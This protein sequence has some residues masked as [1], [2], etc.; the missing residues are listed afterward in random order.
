[1]PA[2]ATPLSVTRKVMAAASRCASSL[3]ADARPVPMVPSSASPAMAL[4]SYFGN[5]VSNPVMTA[6][7]MPITMY[8]NPQVTAAV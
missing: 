5:A 3:S 4:T 8:R 2:M 1:M 7:K 6:P